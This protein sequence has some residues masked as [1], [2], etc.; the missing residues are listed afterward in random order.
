MLKVK[1]GARQGSSEGLD[2]SKVAQTTRTVFCKRKR[3]EKH[4]LE[5]RPKKNESTDG[6]GEFE[7]NVIEREDAFYSKTFITQFSTFQDAFYSETFIARLFF[8]SPGSNDNPKSAEG[9]DNIGPVK[10]KDEPVEKV[11]RNDR[12]A[13]P[14]RLYL[15]RVS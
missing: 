2:V 3:E 6:K 7:S 5:K 15:G 13:T 12:H 14:I 9:P 4:P 10:Q 8:A 1:Q 11:E